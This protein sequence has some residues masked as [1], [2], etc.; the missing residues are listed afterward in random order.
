[1]R[2]RLLGHSINSDEHAVVVQP[3]KTKKKSAKKTL[4]DL[5]EAI[6]HHILDFCDTA[7]GYQFLKGWSCDWP[8]VLRQLEKYSGQKKASAFL[9]YAIGFSSAPL[10]LTKMD[11]D[12]QSTARK[13]AVKLT[14]TP[15]LNWIGMGIGLFVTGTVTYGCYWGIMGEGENGREIDTFTRSS[16]LIYRQTQK[17]CTDIFSFQDNETFQNCTIIQ[18]LPCYSNCTDTVKNCDAYDPYVMNCG[19][20]G[21]SYENFESLGSFPNSWS[22]R[23][24]TNNPVPYT[25]S[26]YERWLNCSAADV[27]AYIALCEKVRSDAVDRDFAEGMMILGAVFSVVC[28]V[29]ILLV[30]SEIGCYRAEGR[31]IMLDSTFS[32]W[33]ERVP[34]SSEYQK[35]ITW[36]QSDVTSL[37]VNEARR[38]LERLI[39]RMNTETEVKTEQKEVKTEQKAESDSPAPVAP[40]GFARTACRFFKYRPDEEAA[41][42]ASKKS[43]LCSA[44]DPDAIQKVSATPG[45]V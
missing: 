26:L 19:K 10:L 1:M 28:M 16:N 23:L 29:F 41:A 11:R 18:N 9:Q 45:G 5:P 20:P 12:I 24:Q 3:K 7:E 17:K 8:M 35:L 6:V 25:T 14:L 21:G 2:E 38:R 30:R 27:A 44:S 42:A 4:A 40:K 43:Q 34:A 13:T 32:D 31:K 33:L 37:P 36:T 22:E 39:T 15:G